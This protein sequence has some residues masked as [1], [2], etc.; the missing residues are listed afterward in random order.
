VELAAGQ[1]GFTHY[2]VMFAKPF[3]MP[4]FLP[5]FGPVLSVVIDRDC[6]LSRPQGRAF[7]LFLSALGDDPVR[8]QRRRRLPPRA[9]GP[10]SATCILESF[11]EP[12]GTLWFIYLLPSFSS[13]QN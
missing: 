4:G 6:H 11:I 13:S 1:T 9:A 8:F 2:V 7:R 12:F 3:R 10:M 5:D